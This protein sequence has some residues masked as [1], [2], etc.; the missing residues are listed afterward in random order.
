MLDFHT[1]P[2]SIHGHHAPATNRNPTNAQQHDRGHAQARRGRT[3][4][5]TRTRVWVCCRHT[6]STTVTSEH[7]RDRLDP[8]SLA[9]QKV[10]HGS[11]WAAACINMAEG[12][13]SQRR[14][15]TQSESWL[16]LLL[17]RL[18]ALHAVNVS[19]IKSTCVLL[20]ATNTR[21]RAPCINHGS[22]EATDVQQRDSR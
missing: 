17:Q 9:M 8:A 2:A 15:A 12:T 7:P 21:E 11:R 5:H 22:V 10:A 3:I 4:G 6:C 16:A 1:Q 19:D 18:A 20:S 14:R 13:I